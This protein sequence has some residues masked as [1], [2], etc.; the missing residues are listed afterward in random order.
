MRTYKLLGSG[1]TFAALLLAAP[2]RAQA[3]GMTDPIPAATARAVVQK[4]IAL[5]ETDGLYPRSQD[6]YAAA[7][8]RLLSALD[9]A[10]EQIDR[11]ALFRHVTAML[12]T[13]DADGHTMIFPPVAERQLRQDFSVA[14]TAER[15][16][17]FALVQTAHGQVLHWTPPQSY[18][19]LKTEGPLFVQ[20]FAADY[21]ALP[22]AARSC[23]L[24]VDL[25]VQYGGNAWPILMT[26][27]PLLSQANRA[28][29]VKRDGER[30]RLFEPQQL[31]GMQAYFGGDAR[32]PLVRF[33]GQP[34]AVVVDGKTSSA[35]EMLL[36]A[37][38]GE[39]ER[40]R[41]FGHTSQGS[42]AANRSHALPDG[43]MLLLTTS[44]YALGDAA[45][46]RG[47]IPAQVPATT[48]ATHADTVRQAADWAARAATLCRQ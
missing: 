28:I 14:R 4:T 25:G 17:S 15:M 41:T 37:M 30:V 42:T 35:G 33:S 23:A 6:E 40:V 48:G 12:Q 19:D 45:P 10:G 7:K 3:L 24:V 2:A 21:A 18:G 5:V 27:H 29:F 11:P 44:R 47:G 13:L 34:L 32:N 22:D 16:S 1:L 43:S 20:R 39:G 46:I 8:A 36:V 38:L 26:M 31:A 9:G